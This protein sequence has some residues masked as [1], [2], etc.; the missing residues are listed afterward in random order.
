MAVIRNNTARTTTVNI[1]F[2]V[3][4]HPHSSIRSTA[5]H[6][7]VSSSTVLRILQD[8]LHT[9]CVSKKNSTNDFKNKKKGAQSSFQEFCPQMMLI[10]LGVELWTDKF[11][12]QGQERTFI[13]YRVHFR[14]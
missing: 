8:H 12:I 4:Q 14:H 5:A 6:D 7:H 11:P 2:Y 10:S 3:E 9:K 13:Q 1:I